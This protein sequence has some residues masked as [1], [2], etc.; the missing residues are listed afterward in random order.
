MKR[1]FEKVFNVGKLYH[2]YLMPSMEFIQNFL[3]MCKGIFDIIFDIIFE[4]HVT[5]N[6]NI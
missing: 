2:N 6:R 1:Y 4:F 5:V 3:I